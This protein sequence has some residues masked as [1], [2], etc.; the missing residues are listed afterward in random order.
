MSQR[1][2]ASLA[3]KVAEASV[4]VVVV[5]VWRLREQDCA[6]RTSPFLAE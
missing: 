2:V 3:Q 1:N 6:N 5:D 4:V